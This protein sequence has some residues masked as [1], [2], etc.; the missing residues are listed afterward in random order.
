MQGQPEG[1]PERG[2][3]HQ[4]G[5]KHRKH[6]CQGE[7]RDLA[8]QTQGSSVRAMHTEMSLGPR[9]LQQLFILFQKQGETFTKSSRPG[10]DTVFEA[11]QLFSAAALSAL[12]FSSTLPRK[13]GGSRVPEAEEAHHAF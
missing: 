5:I 10:G 2:Q 8:V 6:P 3:R 12:K 4:R 7:L 9:K 1:Q 11:S 13:W